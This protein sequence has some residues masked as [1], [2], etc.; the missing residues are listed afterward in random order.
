MAYSEN[1]KRRVLAYV[2]AGG[3]K[4]ETS[5]LFSVARS[6]VYV[7][8]GEPDHQRGKPG[9]KTG[10]KIDRDRLAA[11]IAE[12]PDLLQREMARMMGVSC[13]GISQALKAMGVSRKKRCATPR[14]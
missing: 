11:L 2:A 8:L 1:L 6:T 12:Q 4:L 5:R 7:W 10:Y 13:N 3:G 9:P 14:R